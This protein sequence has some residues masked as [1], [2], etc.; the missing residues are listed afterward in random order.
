MF[1]EVP[2]F[3]A[4]HGHR[5]FVEECFVGEPEMVFSAGTHTDC[6]CMHYADIAE[7]VKPLVGSFG[8]PPVR[9]RSA[10]RVTRVRGHRR[11]AIST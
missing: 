6:L 7:M 5:V 11:A 8:V 1:T 2:P 10:P 3:G 9:T 4:M